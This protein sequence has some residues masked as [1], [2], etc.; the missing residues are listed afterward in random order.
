MPVLKIILTRF[1]FVA[2]LIMPGVGHLPAQPPV[3]REYRIKAAFLFNF[4]QFVDWPTAS[5]STADEPMVIG[6]LGENPFGAYLA[7]TFSGEKVNGHPVLIQHYDHADEIKTCHILFVGLSDPKK[8]QEVIS[9]LKER[10]ILTISDM[11]GFLA[12][13]GMIKFFMK[14]NN[15]RFEINLEATKAANLVLSSKLLRL[16]EIFDASKNK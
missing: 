16:A 10:S 8:S 2:L 3:P 4:T 9:D 13:G 6:V 14:D 12:Q 1:L 7:E 5:F 15:I 11:P